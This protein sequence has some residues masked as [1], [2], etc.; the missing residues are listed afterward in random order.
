MSKIVWKPGTMLYPVPAVLVSSR[1]KKNDN[2]LTVGWAGTVCTDPPMLSIS[3]RPERYSYTL[4]SK[5]GEFV[6]NV[7]GHD[8]A[9]A[10][11]FCGVR[12]GRDVDKF[13]LLKLHR[14]DAAVVNVPL[15]AECPLCIEARVRSVTEL[16]SHH[17]F[18]AEVAA[19]NVE[20]SLLDAK[21]KL[22]L[23]RARLL[24]YSHGFYYSV[25]KPLGRFGFSVMKKKKRP[26]R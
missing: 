20:G 26:E 14:Q 24:C 13:S 18:L 10:V 7:P 4:I 5:S 23:D 19:V 6:V 15:I 16:G 17:M 9:Y 11:D 8:L 21:G 1:Y 3:L 22:R 12:S 25:S 2:I